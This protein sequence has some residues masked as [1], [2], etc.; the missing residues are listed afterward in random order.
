MKEGG[1]RVR[2]RSLPS[3]TPFNFE[4]AHTIIYLPERGH[5][6]MWGSLRESFAILEAS[7]D[8]SGNLV[9]PS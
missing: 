8:G 4:Y 1:N 3:L 7:L 5:K 2:D 6:K 9:K